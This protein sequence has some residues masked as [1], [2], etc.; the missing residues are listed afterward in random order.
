MEEKKHI[1]DFVWWVIPEKLLGVRKPENAEE[2]QFLKSLNVG[3]I[4]T[5]LDD[6]ENQELYK[7]TEMD[8]LWLPVKGGSAPTKEQAQA[9][10]QFVDKLNSQGRV[11]A[12]HCNNGRK[13][14]GALL[15]SLLVLKGESPQEALDK[16]V[17]LNPEAKLSELQQDFIKSLG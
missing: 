10:V 5:L 3:G 15:A 4:V 11:I 13:R 14:N 1:S 8:F 9:A 17:T 2:V 6:H 12:V 7:K 16:I